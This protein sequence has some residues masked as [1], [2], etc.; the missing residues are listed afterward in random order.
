MEKLILFLHIP[1]TAGTTMYRLMEKQYPGQV[2]F[3]LVGKNMEEA[4]RLI[5]A[6]LT[7]TIKCFYGHFTFGIHN[8]F[9]RPCTYITLLRD[10]IDR[11]ISEYYFLL[12]E[13]RHDPYVA[14]QLIT[15]NMTLLDYVTSTD[16]AFVRR[17]NNMQTRFITGNPSPRYEDLLLAKELLKKYFHIGITERFNESLFLLQKHF[18]WK[19][20]EPFPSYFVNNSRPTKH[21]ISPD[22]LK[23]IADKNNLDLLLYKEANRLFQKRLN[24]LDDASQK[25]LTQFLKKLD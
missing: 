5:S 1:K 17:T 21:S 15:K 12:E 11:V 16:E 10:P 20:C 14:N 7:C 6:D 9:T 18:G 19:E 22:V 2:W 4:I 8:Q 3:W 25:E 23:V 24:A 13:P